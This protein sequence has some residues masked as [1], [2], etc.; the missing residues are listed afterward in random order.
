[1]CSWSTAILSKGRENIQNP[2]N[3]LQK[4]FSLLGATAAW[5]WNSWWTQFP[6]CNSEPVW[7]AFINAWI[8]VA[9]QDAVAFIYQSVW[10]L[11]HGQELVFKKRQLFQVVKGDDMGIWW[12]TQSWVH[13]CLKWCRVVITYCSCHK[14]VLVTTPAVS[15][16]L[17]SV[18][19]TVCIWNCVD[20]YNLEQLPQTT[21]DCY[22]CKA[23]LEF[24]CLH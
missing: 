12:S 1:M 16:Q 7:Q 20:G 6:H 4:Y 9:K 21:C 18:F 2:K 17:Q 8:N 11:V 19:V 3:R 13:R 14:Y 15:C 5:S 10:I 24:L 23:S 22:L